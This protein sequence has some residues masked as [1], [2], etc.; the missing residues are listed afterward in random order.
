MADAL[1]SMSGLTGDGNLA[2]L[3]QVNVGLPGTDGGSVP[4]NG[5]IQVPGS[6][7]L[8][9]T[10]SPLTAPVIPGSGTTFWIIQVNTTTGA[11]S[12]KTS[13]SATPAPDASN[14][15]VFQSSL[16][17]GTDTSAAFSAASAFPNQW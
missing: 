8:V 2:T 17:H 1:K 7:K 6:A 16:I 4:I 11:A 13:S 10:G 3:V 12:I 15:V 14:I 9:I 5:Q